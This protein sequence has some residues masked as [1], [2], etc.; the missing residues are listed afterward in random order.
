MCIS[1]SILYSP[2][3]CTFGV[4]FELLLVDSGGQAK[5]H[6]E[7]LVLRPFLQAH[8]NVGAFYIGMDVASAVDVL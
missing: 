7:G 5:V 4:R 3:V 2:V 8:E 6:Q 1:A